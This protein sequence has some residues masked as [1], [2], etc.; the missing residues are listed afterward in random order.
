MNLSDEAR[1][2]FP[3]N[4]SE[5]MDAADFFNQPQKL[6]TRAAHLAFEETSGCK[7]SSIIRIRTEK[8]GLVS[9]SVDT[10]SKPALPPPLMTPRR[11]PQ[12]PP[13]KTPSS[14]TTRRNSARMGVAGTML[15]TPS[16]S[17]NAVT[18]RQTLTGIR[19]SVKTGGT[20][21]LEPIYGNVPNANVSSNKSKKNTARKT[22]RKNQ[23]RFQTIGYDGEVR[24]PLK[25]KKNKMASATVQ[26]SKSAQTPSHKIQVN[27]KNGGK[28]NLL[29]HD[30]VQRSLSLR[31]PKPQIVVPASLRETI[32]DVTTPKSEKVKRHLS[33]RV[34]T[35]KAGRPSEAVPFIKDVL[36]QSRTLRS[37]PGTPG[38]QY[39]RTKT[40]VSSARKRHLQ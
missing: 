13:A 21:K 5:W 24:S 12:R 2:D 33:D 10:F 14:V 37:S 34:M 30:K 26:R 35:P 8:K 36:T 4:E 11:G 19:T 18:R 32:Y 40:L 7:R 29:L 20:P 6:T 16:G 3:S 22:Q 15:A 17:S 1:D 27:K 23:R 39:L 9:R 25:D 38:Q 28:E 31:S